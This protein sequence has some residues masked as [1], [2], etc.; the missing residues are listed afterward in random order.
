M[1]SESKFKDFTSSTMKPLPVIVLADVSGSMRKEGK[2]DALNG[3]IKKMIDTFADEEDLRAEIQ[4]SI[5]TFGDTAARVHTELQAASQV[6]WTGMEAN[7]GTPMGHAM[8]LANEMIEDQSRV[9]SE[10]YRPTLVLV[11]DGKPNDRDR[12]FYECLSRLID[13]GRSSKAERIALGIGGDTNQEVLERF[14]NDPDKPIFSADDAGQI[15]EFFELVTMSV[16]KRS[17]SADP[18]SVPPVD[19]STT[20][21]YF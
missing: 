8:D 9:P 10:A 12:N 2:I 18:N 11:S 13:E 7:G 4:V 20:I 15:K 19:D 6:E 21:N 3:A 1:G 5:I 14:V 17:Q 16:T